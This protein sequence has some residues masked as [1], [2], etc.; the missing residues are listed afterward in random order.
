MNAQSIS[1]EYSL[2]GIHDMASGFRFSKDGKF[3]FFYIYGVVDRSASGTYTIE[4]DTI[5]LQSDKEP[6]KDFQITTESKK[7]KGFTIQASAPNEYL[8]Q[9]ITCIYFAGE[10]K[11]YAQSDSKGLIHID[12]LSCDTIYLLHE[13]FADIPTLIKDKDNTNNYFEVSLSPSL[14]NV[15]FKGIDLFIK[16]KGD[17]LSCLPNYFMPFENIRYVKE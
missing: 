13:L 11:E 1:G 14:V 7:G 4:G 8:L 12:V 10:Q 15:S 3:D 6:G 17:E 5:K 2:Q 16:D 9:N